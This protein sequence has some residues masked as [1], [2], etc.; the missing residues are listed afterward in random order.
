VSRE[1]RANLNEKG[2]S[3]REG[4]SRT[5]LLFAYKDGSEKKKGDCADVERGAPLPLKKEPPLN[6]ATIT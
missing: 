2:K 6:L 1:F 3:G 5:Q 4:D